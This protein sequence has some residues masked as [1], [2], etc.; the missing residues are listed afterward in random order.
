MIGKELSEHYPV[1]TLAKQLRPTDISQ[2]N[3]QE[4]S[5]TN[6]SRAEKTIRTAGPVVLKLG[7]LEL[8]GFSG[9]P[10]KGGGSPGEP[11]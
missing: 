6:N 11:E 2:M 5:Y 9:D 8:V 10:A 3:K 7:S 1:L 4:N